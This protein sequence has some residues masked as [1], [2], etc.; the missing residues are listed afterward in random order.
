MW[1]IIA[2]IIIGI[3]LL[4]AELVL[5]PGLSVAG[6]CSLIAYFGAIFATFKT[7]GSTAG[8]I[9][10]GIIVVLSVVAA[11]ISLKANTWQRFS[12]KTRVDGT[13][14]EV[15]SKDNIKIGALA[16][17]I[18]RLAPMGKVELD[19]KTYEAKSLDRYVDPGVAVEVI[20]FENFNIIV[21]QTNN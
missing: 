11:V 7:Y 21:K 20:G 5:L 8:F 14:Q 13:S 3:L 15:L 1:L 16:K 12:L 6:V 4:I 10:I 17:T 19:G 9:V 18:T 2:L